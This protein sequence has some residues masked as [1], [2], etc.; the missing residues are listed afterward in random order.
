MII[1][2][3]KLSLWGYPVVIWAKAKTPHVVF[4]VLENGKKLLYTKTKKMPEQSG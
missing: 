3:K 1:N 2:V 4:D